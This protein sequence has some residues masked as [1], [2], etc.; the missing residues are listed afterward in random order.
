M[1]YLS[2]TLVE[3]MRGLPGILSVQEAADFL[4]V[5]TDTVYRLIKSGELV[6]YRAAGEGPAWNIRRLD[7]QAYLANHSSL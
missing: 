2:E 6:A 7:L 3:M 1:P 4:S 5:S